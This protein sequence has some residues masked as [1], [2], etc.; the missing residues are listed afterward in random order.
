MGENFEPASC[1]PDFITLRGQLI[2]SPTA[3]QWQSVC[4]YPCIF[5]TKLFS[6]D[7]SPEMLS[8]LAA[9]FLFLCVQFVVASGDTSGGR[10]EHYVNDEMKYGTKDRHVFKENMPSM[11][12]R[13]DLL[14]SDRVHGATVHEVV[15]VIRQRNMEEL[16]GLLHDVSNPDS[17][18]YGQHLTQEKVTSMTTNPESRDAVLSYLTSVGSK[19]KSVTRGGDFII[20]E[21]SVAVWEEAF[22]AE[23]F[24]LQQTLPSGQT[25]EVIRA[26][27]YSIPSELHTHVE[28]VLNILEIPNGERVGSRSKFSPQITKYLVTPSKLRKFYNV[29][30]SQGSS[31]STQ[32]AYGAIGQY[33]S[34]ADLRTFQKNQNLTY[35]TAEDI[36]SHSSDFYCRISPNDC[37]EANL[38]MQYIMSMSPGSPTTY[39]YASYGMTPWLVEV[40]RASRVP[41]VLSISYGQE[42]Q[43]VTEAIKDA[44]NTIAMKLSA[45]GVTILVA[46]GDDGANSR[47]VRKGYY[48]RCGYQPDFPSVSPYLTAVGAT[49]VGCMLNVMTSCHRLQLPY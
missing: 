33:F 10:P 31:L 42:E 22:K 4:R 3:T 13:S 27:G 48:S 45:M 30:S 39:W 37:S 8:Y 26:D 21:A 14:W 11:S 2:F 15:F 7:E 36:G 17:P 35:Q 43:Y 47:N 20:A 28:S 29:S 1:L 44:F 32:A 25:H 46:S 19:V 9:V 41:L 16:T 34:P 18:N 24:T 12:M 38:D 6:Y 40:S 5:C 23:F 49:S